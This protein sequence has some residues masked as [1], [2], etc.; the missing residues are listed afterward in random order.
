MLLQKVR[1]RRRADGGRLP[2]Q[3]VGLLFGDA[4][5]IGPGLTLGAVAHVPVGPVGVGGLGKALPGLEKVRSRLAEGA[6]SLGP[7]SQGGDGRGEEQGE[8]EK[9]GGDAPE[10]RAVVCH[11]SFLSLQLRESLTFLFRITQV[12]SARQPGSEAL[13]LPAIL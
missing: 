7:G 6:G 1:H 9:Q 3:P 5:G 12:S 11:V 4:F 2:Q 10:V 13:L 8:Q